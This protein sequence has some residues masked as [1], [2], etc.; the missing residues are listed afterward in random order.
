MTTTAP[1]AIG[2]VAPYYCTT[3]VRGYITLIFM[4]IALSNIGQDTRVSTNWCLN[5]KIVKYDT[6]RTEVFLSQLPL[7]NIT[8]KYRDGDNLE[9]PVVFHIV[10]NTPEENLTDEAVLAILDQMNEGFS[11]SNSSLDSVRSVFLQNVADV[12]NQF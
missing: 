2:E 11:A 3:M 5:D 7:K 4:L 9:I 1:I 6:S 12:G 8:N 10:W